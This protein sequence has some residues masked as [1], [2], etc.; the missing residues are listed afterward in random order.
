MTTWDIRAEIRSRRSAVMNQARTY[1]GG[2]CHLCRY[3]TCTEALEFHHV[4][5][6]HKNFE[7]SRRT[8][9]FAAM[10]AELDKCVLLCCRCH[11]EVHAGYHPSYLVDPNDAAGLPLEEDPHG[12]FELGSD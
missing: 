11:R 7:I 1:L 2:C 3:A 9:N 4:N 5:P 8:S 10:K 6:V 12:F